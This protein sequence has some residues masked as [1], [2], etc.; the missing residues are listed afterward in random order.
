MPRKAR[1]TY[2]REIERAANNLDMPM[3]HLLRVVEAYKE[4]HPD[5]A[6]YAEVIAQTLANAQE[7]INNLN[8]LI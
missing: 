2:K 3:T 8:K 1:Q 5:I 6:N 4:H 7:A